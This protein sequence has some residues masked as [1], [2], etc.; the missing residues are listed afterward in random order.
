MEPVEIKKKLRK[1]SEAG[2][3]LAIDFATNL[4]VPSKG[5]QCIVLNAYEHTNATSRSICKQLYKD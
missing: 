5:N 2:F 4:A 3:A 1:G